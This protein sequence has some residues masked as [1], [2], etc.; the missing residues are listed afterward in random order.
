MNTSFIFISVLMIPKG[1]KMLRIYLT[2]CSK[3][4]RIIINVQKEGRIM[5]DIRVVKSK[6][7]IVKSLFI[8]LDIEKYQHITVEQ[9]CQYARCSR[10][11][12]YSH[13]DSKEGV[14]KEIIDDYMSQFNDYAKKR[15]NENTD[16]KNLLVTLINE[17]ILPE[18][19]A[20][21]RILQIELDGLGLSNRFENFCKEVFITHYSDIPSRNI[22]GE[23]YGACAVKV[24]KAIIE[25]RLEKMDI[26]V[27]NEMQKNLF[28]SSIFKR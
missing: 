8:L 18:K 25:E 26:R 17:L 15:F 4:Y 1:Y 13:Y 21:K 5:V 27:I 16:F 9:I 23:L 24:L 20:I 11:T 10:S 7:N 22:I 12:F 2:I 3:T 28:S 6:E 19:K 14:L